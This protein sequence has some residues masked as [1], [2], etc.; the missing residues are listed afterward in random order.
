[1]ETHV[2]LSQIS[3][4]YWPGRI[5]FL[6]PCSSHI[7]VYFY[8][9]HNSSMASLLTICTLS[10]HFS[11]KQKLIPLQSE[12]SWKI[13][14]FVSKNGQS[15]LAVSSAQLIVSFLRFYSKTLI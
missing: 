3:A 1:M 8:L 15:N 6:P 13:L 12:L 10:Y 14:L 4:K 11:F 2:H 9:G 5:A 7:T